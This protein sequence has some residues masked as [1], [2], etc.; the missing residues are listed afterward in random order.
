MD[1]VKPQHHM[2]REMAARARQLAEEACAL[3]AEARAHA[4]VAQRLMTR[5]RSEAHNGAAHERTAARAADAAPA[6]RRSRRSRSRQ[7][8]GG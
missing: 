1:R 4:E 6:R 3:A 5:G 7:K 8:A 2:L